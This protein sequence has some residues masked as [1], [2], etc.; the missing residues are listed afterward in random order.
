MALYELKRKWD[1][2][3]KRQIDLKNDIMVREKKLEKE[4]YGKLKIEM[5]LLQANQRYL[6]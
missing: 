2:A 6:K 1:G 4:S 3:E 5:K